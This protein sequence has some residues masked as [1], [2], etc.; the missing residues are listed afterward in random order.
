[1]GTNGIGPIPLLDTIQASLNFFDAH[2]PERSYRWTGT[3]ESERP[4]NLEKPDPHQV[5][6]HD[7]RGSSEEERSHWGLTLDQAGFEILQGW[8][9]EDGDK[10][11]KAWEVRRWEDEGWILG[12]YYEYVER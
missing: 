3:N 4:I 9:G 10:M 11:E 7:L 1:M 6:I 12:E 8:T 2:T 5:Q